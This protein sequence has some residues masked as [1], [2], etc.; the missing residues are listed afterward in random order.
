ML[1]HFQYEY[2]KCRIAPFSAV[3]G[4]L[5]ACV[6]NRITWISV[7]GIFVPD[8]RPGPKF[9]SFIPVKALKIRLFMRVNEVNLDLGRKSGRKISWAKIL[10]SHSTWVARTMM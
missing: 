6:F 5:Q 9:T 8:F 10:A 3:N 1:I 7:Q 4:H 2:E